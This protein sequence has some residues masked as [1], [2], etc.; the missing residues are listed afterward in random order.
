MKS[1]KKLVAV[2]LVAAMVLACC[3]CGGSATNNNAL[4][5]NTYVAGFP[6]VKEKEKLEIMTVKQ[7]EH[8]D[9]DEMGFTSYYEEMTNIDIEW[10]VS[11]LSE[12]ESNLTLMFQ[13]KNLPD[14]ISLPTGIFGAERLLKYSKN[15]QVI[16][17][18]ELIDKYAPNI[19]K[20]LETSKEFKMAATSADGKIYSLPTVQTD[21][22][23]HERF[24]QKM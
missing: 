18:D 24:P 6:I 13:S 4:E 3:A 21:S 15:G 19:K 20:L 22:N 17:L 7:V 12:Y 9:F 11:T 10:M 5:G 23:N 8:G 1:M 14:V 2:L 16:Q